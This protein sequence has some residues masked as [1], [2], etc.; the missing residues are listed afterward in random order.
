[1]RRKKVG[2][3]T[4]LFDEVTAVLPARSGDI[5]RRRFGMVPGQ[6]RTLDGVGKHY[7]LTRER[8]RQ[9]I[10]A[11]IKHVKKNLTPAMKRKIYQSLENKLKKS[12]HI[13]P[14]E[15]LIKSFAGDDP[16]EAG[17]I[18]FFIE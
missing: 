8:I 17:A 11:A 1:M 16:V 10:A 9:I 14:E 6:A 15:D 5:L 13:M 7:G 2:K 4:K 12:G 3:F 18:R